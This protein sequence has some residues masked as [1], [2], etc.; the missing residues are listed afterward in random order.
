M[1]APESGGL[2]IVTVYL[3]IRLKVAKRTSMQWLTRDI[4]EPQPI[5]QCFIIKTRKGKAGL[6]PPLFALVLF[7]FLECVPLVP[8][9]KVDVPSG[10]LIRTSSKILTLM[11]L[12]GSIVNNAT[13]VGAFKSSVFIIG[14]RINDAY[15][16]QG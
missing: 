7:C 6:L 14:I 10:V 3:R 5:L 8:L 4:F 13:R 16:I 12:S 15:L 11:L 2:C 9:W 1:V